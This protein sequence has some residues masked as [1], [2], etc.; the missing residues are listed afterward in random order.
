VARED[1]GALPGLNTQQICS[2][3]CCWLQTI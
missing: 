2:V 1:A 3:C